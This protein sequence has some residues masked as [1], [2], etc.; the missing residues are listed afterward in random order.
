VLYDPPVLSSFHLITLIA[1][2]WELFYFIVIELCIFFF[3]GQRYAIMEMKT[4][5]SSIVRNFKI[6]SLN[7]TKD[8]HPVM[9]LTLTPHGGVHIELTLRENDKEK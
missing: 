3:T 8:I 6:R 2:D 4:V 9:G 5:L 1:F 7:K